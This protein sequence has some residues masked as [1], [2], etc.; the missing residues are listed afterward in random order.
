MG[1]ERT[2]QELIER[3]DAVHRRI[4][5]FQRELFGLI[6]EADRNEVWR[7]S[8]ARDMAAWLSMR[9]GMS[10]WKARRWI[11]AAG[12]LQVLPRISEAFSGEL[13]WTRWWSSPGSP[14]SR[15]KLG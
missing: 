13:G 2:N 1:N 8:G 15:P 7:D 4:C 12:A 10:E 6:A 9:Y 3:T 14:P 5:A 11:A